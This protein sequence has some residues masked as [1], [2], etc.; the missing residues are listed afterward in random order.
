MKKTLLLK[1]VLSYGKSQK[2]NIAG[3]VIFTLISVASALLLPVLIGG[4]I[5]FILGAN[6]VDFSKIIIQIG[7][8]L[9]TVAFGFVAQWLSS[10]CTNSITFHIS[11]NLRNDFFLKLNKMP[12]STIEGGTQGDIVARITTDVEAVGAGLLQGFSSLFNGVITIAGTLGLMLYINPLIAAVV[13]VFTPLSIFF[14]A[15]IAKKIHVQFAKQAKI[16]GKVTAFTSEKFNGQKTVKLFSQENNLEKEFAKIN[17]ELYDCG[18]KAQFYAAL[19]NPTTRCINNVI[20]AIVGVLGVVLA[21]FFGT[22]TAGSLTTFLM[23]SNQYTKPFNEISGVIA[24]LQSAFASAERVLEFMEKDEEP[25]D[26]LLPAISNCNG[27]ITFDNVSFGYSKDKLL[28]NNLFLAIKHGQ[29]VAVIGKTGCGKTTLI[30]LIMR[31]YD[32]SGG[33]IVVGGTPSDEVTRKSLRSCFGMVLQDS[34]LFEGSVRDNIA[35]G[36]PDAPLEEI[37]AAAKNANADEFI[38]KLPSGYDSIIQSGGHNLSQ[39]Q[40][41]LLC[42]SRIMLTS[43]P[44]LILDEATSNID[45]RTEAKVNDA[46]QKLMSGR[47]SIIVAHRLTTVQN[48]DLILVMKNGDI[49]E[50]GNHKE[51]ISQSGYYKELYYSQYDAED[52]NVTSDI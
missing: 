24:E 1:K 17:T 6:N 12:I 31:F 34:W 15:I 50:S 10:L 28:M 23:Y 8:I 30:N 35:F 4:A 39:G 26:S 13:I 20:Y 7:Y 49:I 36:N 32:L 51:L 44:M 48:A 16:Q 43:P 29:K 46:F 9:I 33:K 3:A 52:T 25:S 18:F 2:L 45:T 41:Q 47:T 22:V 11:E 19:V 5:D 21:F 40:R 37:I 14:A 38:Q 42:I 27:D